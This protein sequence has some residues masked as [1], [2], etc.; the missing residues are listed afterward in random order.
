MPPS[1][2]ERDQP[3]GRL[4]RAA[5]QMW[6]NDRFHGVKLLCR[7]AKRVDSTRADP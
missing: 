5:P 7:I 6:W 3:V 1:L 2:E 4:E